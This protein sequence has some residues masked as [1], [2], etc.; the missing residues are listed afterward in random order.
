MTTH[1]MIDLETLGNKPDTTVLTLGGVKF[2]PN[3][4]SEPHSELYFRL[5]VDEQSE[6]FGLVVKTG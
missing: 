2:N 3:A 6:Y 5:D 1:A 4:I